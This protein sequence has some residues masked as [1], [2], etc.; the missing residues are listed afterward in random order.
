MREGSRPPDAPAA[1]AGA[2][3]ADGDAGDVHALRERISALCAASVRISASLDLPTL[4]GEIVDSA[5]ALTGARYGAV[6]TVDADGQLQ[7]FVTRGTN[8]AEHRRLLEWPDGPRL[9]QRLRDLPGPIRLADLPSHL[10]ALGLDGD[11]LLPYRTFQGT[12]MRHLGEHVGSFWLAEKAGGA[13]FTADDEEL[14]VLFAAQAA[15]AIANARAFRDERRARAD[16]EALVDTSPV[17]VA[18]FD[19]ATGRLVSLNREARR[20]VERLR[21][22]GHTTEDLLDV[23]TCRRADGRELA[24]GEFPLATALRSA[25]TVRAEEIVLSVPD[26]PSVATLLS[27]TPVR[28]DAGVETVVITL[29]DLAPLEELDRM[30]ADFLGMVSH[31][32]RVPLTSIKG[33]TATVLDARRAFGVAELVQFFRIVDDQADRMTDLIGDLLDAGSIDAGT[34][35]VDAEPSDAG[36]LIDA[37]RGAFLAGGTGHDVAIDLPA[38]LPRVMADR[39]RVVQV[40]GNLLANAARHAPPSPIRVTATLDGGHVE[41]S[42]ADEGH[43]VAP[44]ELPNLFRKYAG[45]APGAGS[46]G[47]GLGLAICKGIVEAHGGRI[48]AESA[49]PGTGTLVAFT[50]PVADDDSAATP[51]AGARTPAAGGRAR[52]LVVDDDPRTLRFAREALDGAGF[53]TMATGNFRDLARIL[54]AER[55]AL[56][57][58]DLVLPGSDG[59]AL[60]A[61]V[62]ALAELPVI[63]ISAYGRDETIARALDAGADDY[64]VKPFSATELT[65]RVR[66]ALRRRAGPAAFA[67]GELAIDYRGRRAT[68]AGREL[69]LTATEHD[70]L[71]A[72]ARNAG[73]VCSYH[74]LARLVWHRRHVDPKLV[75][76]FVRRL[77]GKL[78][79]AAAKPVYIL[80]ERG[81]GYR[82]ATPP[83]R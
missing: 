61:E 1:P 47:R 76:A 69:G 74:D 60:M 32:L 2:G 3:Q 10:S 19:A 54:D 31:E 16:L 59:V 71:C 11:G 68:L 81:V 36:A 6:T 8:E 30:R 12:P 70:L 63:F 18:V 75:R 64:L 45:R 58:L 43:G 7:D 5:R 35:S 21:Q 15:V 27:A 24:L 53:D 51:T 57:L 4:L 65:A 29:Q 78:G 25:E 49:G 34:L 37:A 48:R 50:L 73:G 9:F 14:L 26:G 41:L 13:G 67:L 72:L 22:P 20:I 38:D 80:T 44:E 23:V 83:D 42:V 40:L 56:V 55:P 62:P 52:I 79:D 66:A 17:G 46:S 28:G 33:A 39:A 82:M 77:R